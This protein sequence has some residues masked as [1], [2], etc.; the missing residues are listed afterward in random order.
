VRRGRDSHLSQA[1]IELLASERVSEKGL[2]EFEEIDRSGAYA[3]V[4]KCAACK[5]LV[6]GY[7]LA[8]NRLSELRMKEIL[9]LQSGCPPEEE[10][11]LAVA[12]SLPEEL[13]EERFQ[14]ASHCAHC[15]PLL[16]LAAEVFTDDCTPEEEALLG[17][18]AT[19][20]PVWQRQFAERVSDSLNRPTRS[21]GFL[22]S[23]WNHLRPMP[24]LTLSF[25]AILLLALTIWLVK[26]RHPQDPRQLLAQAYSQQRTLELRIAGANYA[27]V[28]VLR[29]TEVSRVNRPTSLLEAEALIAKNIRTNANDVVWLHTQ[30]LADLLENNY[31][32]AISVLDKAHRYTPEDL[33]VSVDLAT[34]Y[35]LRAEELNLPA[36]F[37]RA[38]ELQTE[39]LAKKPTDPIALFN[40]AIAEERLFLFKQAEQDWQDYLKL[41]ASSGW[42]DE[43]R[44]RLA[45]LRERIKQSKDR[46]E[47]PLL[48]PSEFVTALRQGS[49]DMQTRVNDRVESYLGHALEE[50][51]PR[52]LRE[53]HNSTDNSQ[54]D[55]VALDAL[56][57]LLTAKH[58]DRWLAD[59]LEELHSTPAASDGARYLVEASVANQT[60]D[61]ARA[62]YLAQKAVR[63]FH[64]TGSAAGELRAR[65]EVAYADQ[66]AHDAAPCFAE[67]ER[68]SHSDRMRRYPWLHT[69]FLLEMAACSSL[70]DMQ[71]R[72]FAFQALGVSNQSKYQTLQL[73]ATTFL[74]GLFEVDG[75]TTQAWRYSIDGLQQYWNGTYPPMRGYS[76][77]AGLDLIAEQSREWSLDVQ[78]IREALQL[79]ASDSDVGL[80]AIE[81]HRLARALVI[82]GALPEAER[83]FRISQD[84]FLRMPVDDR[85]LNLEFETQ[86]G[87]AGIELLQDTPTPAIA[88]L[89]RLQ[90][91]L[92]TLSDKDLLFDFYRTRGLA[93]LAAGD[94]SQAQENLQ[95]ALALS[96]KSLA[97]NADERERL[98]WSRKTDSAYR[99]MVR[100]K[101]H[102]EP[103]AALAD[104][105]WYK[106]ASLR[107]TQPTNR[108]TSSSLELSEPISRIAGDTS[109]VTY[110]VFPE[111]VSVWVSNREGVK[112]RWLNIGE[113]AISSD[114]RLFGKHCSDPDFD[115]DILR[116]EG[117]RLYLNLVQPIE[118][119]V[120]GYR[121]LII[122]PDGDLWF[123]P[124]EGLVDAKGSYL[125]DRVDLSFSPGLAYLNRSELWPGI[126]SASH[127]L[128]VGDANPAPGQ[129]RLPDAV[130][131]LKGIASRFRY[132][133]LVSQG[134]VTS[135]NINRE[136]DT[137]DIFHFSGHA[138]TS[139]DRP[140]LVLSNS[141]VFGVGKVRFSHF[142]NPKLVVLS[143]CSTAN[144]GTGVFDD[145]DSLARLLIGSGVSEVVASRWMVD[146]GATS[147]LMNQFYEQL[148]SGQSVS[149][150]LR[151]A[152]EGLRKQKQ[153]AH[154]FYWAAFA[155]FGK[156]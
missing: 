118:G 30:G 44:K 38:I 96:E 84:L 108:E 154:P 5:E 8:T 65:L 10:W 155:A 50:W 58:Q 43:A 4:A 145:E 127:A 92:S 133:H 73:R 9:P 76:L 13:I 22:V 81:Q 89:N 140:G 104:W 94:F 49:R 90:P 62:R 120:R 45:A 91:Q 52:G 32:S 53:S 111:G 11:L 54:R 156:N 74:A 67:A 78:V 1:E 23:L 112:Q 107:S 113:A 19:S 98:I 72:E 142:K 82:T 148:L 132:N 122:E 97:A 116:A 31:D 117:S 36:D 33:Q 66:L 24:R 131:E 86:V 20:T 34:A 93:N 26:P 55:N 134:A 64:T 75:D 99:G 83:T 135:E 150:A 42:A 143:A 149:G 48:G 37:G 25:V 102:T 105:E 153:F 136:L 7:V 110:A 21:H 151:K 17:A 71:A 61:L 57:V 77:Y 114:A 47:I 14:H 29:G 15:G 59:F 56:A 40:R 101:L 146:S 121:H 35:F 28:H 88:R 109:V 68:Q 63:I 87:L 123:I 70:A 126:S 141:E 79:I 129:R 130:E 46:S 137:V 80:Q 103:Q 144:G 106:S 27:P 60:S 119:L 6:E 2:S 100:L 85:K 16:K 139:P 51:L 3:H 152:S 147:E 138:T 125:Q 124:F 12:E 69:Q 39:V 18:L 95:H 41:D 115:L 128:I